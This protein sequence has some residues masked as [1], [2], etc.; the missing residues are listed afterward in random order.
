MVR[1]DGNMHECELVD[2]T[3][4]VYKVRLASGRTVAVRNVPVLRCLECQEVSLWPNVARMV[5]R[6]A[7]VSPFESFEYPGGQPISAEGI[8]AIRGRLGVS[9]PKFA[10]MLGKSAMSVSHWE[11][12][13]KKPDGSSVVLMRM[14]E[15]L[16]GCAPLPELVDLSVPENQ[17]T[18]QGTSSAHREGTESTECQWLAPRRHDNST[19]REVLRKSSCGAPFRDR[20]ESASDFFQPEKPRLTSL[21][22]RDMENLPA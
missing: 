19:M 2:A 8:Q 12:G 7:E 9:Q 11:T 5:D 1:R 4:D 22:K 3:V 10:V 6:L 21:R 13:R 14:L 15:V 17:A 18:D 16:S 20:L